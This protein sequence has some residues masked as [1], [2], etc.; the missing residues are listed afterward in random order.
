M[1]GIPRTYLLPDVKCHGPTTVGD[2]LY[3]REV[4]SDQLN[5]EITTEVREDDQE[6]P[7][8]ITADGRK[9]VENIEL[10]ESLLPGTK[11]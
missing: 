6:T 5:E 9:A 7:E 1:P 3:A 11:E 2:L 4:D 8:R 10:P